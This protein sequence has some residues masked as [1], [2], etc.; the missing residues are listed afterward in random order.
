MESPAIERRPR[1]SNRKALEYVLCMALKRMHST[2][3]VKLSRL[4]SSSRLRERQIQMELYAAI[5]TLLPSNVYVVPEWKTVM[6]SRF[7]DLVSAFDD[8]IWFLELLGGW[9]RCQGACQ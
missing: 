5:A 6:R 9:S 1:Y 7:V 3:L 4:S 8:N 2:R